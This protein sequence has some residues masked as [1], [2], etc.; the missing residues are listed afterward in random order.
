MKVLNVCGKNYEDELKGMIPVFV[1]ITCMSVSGLSSQQRYDS[2]V[3][4]MIGFLSSVSRQQWYKDVFDHGETLK[5]IVQ[6]IL[7]RNIRL[8]ESDIELYEMSGDEWVTK[9]IE[10]SNFE[11]RRR[12]AT[13]LLSG[14]LEHYQEKI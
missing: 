9:D 10:G 14:L 8:R 4:E 12:V 2:L 7:I 5:N 3:S 13:D 11:T 6:H 1:K